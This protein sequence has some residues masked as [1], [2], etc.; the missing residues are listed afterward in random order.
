MDRQLTG[1]RAREVP[2]STENSGLVSLFLT[3]LAF[4]SLPDILAVLIVKSPA[5]A[6]VRPMLFAHGGWLFFLPGFLVASWQ[7]AGTEALTWA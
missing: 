5:L 6:V 3:S 4:F 2:A 7:K 1:A